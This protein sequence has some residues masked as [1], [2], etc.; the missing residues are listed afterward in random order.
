MFISFSG[1]PGVRHLAACHGE[2]RMSPCRLWTR[3]L[4]LLGAVLAGSVLASNPA[5]ALDFAEAQ[6][7]AE[8]QSPRASAQQLQIDA[9]QSAQKAAGSLPDPKLSVGIENLPVSGMDRWSLT[10]ES[11]TMQRIALMQEVPNQAKRDAQVASAQARVARERAALVLQRLQIRQEFSLAWIAARAVE[12]REQFLSDLLT[13]NQR[14]QDSLPA[15][16]AGARPRRATCWQRSRRRWRCRIGVMICSGIVP[17]PGPCCDGGW[18]PAPM[19]RCKEI[20]AH[21]FIQ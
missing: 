15:R 21:S 9:A 6:K 14:L 17:R 5:Y 8:E 3:Q 11:M 2:T 1:A 20:P 4:S 19:K 7:I 16:V 13:E 18:A 10:R 12:Q